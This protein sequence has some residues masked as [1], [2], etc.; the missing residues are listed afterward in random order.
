MN[1]HTLS[2]ASLESTVSA[3]V[4]FRSIPNLPHA[5]LEF[6]CSPGHWEPFIYSLLSGEW[7]GNPDYSFIH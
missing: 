6:S 5:S 1:L 7:G 3:S 4:R 2:R